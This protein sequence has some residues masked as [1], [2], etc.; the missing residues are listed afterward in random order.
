MSLLGAEYE[1]YERKCA[2]C[3]VPLHMAAAYYRYVE[4][5]IAP[6]GFLKAVLMNDLCAAASR[7]DMMNA[8]ALVEH[9]RFCYNHLPSAAWGCPENYTVWLQGGS[10]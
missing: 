5:R 2:E 7:A 8:R 10:E 1:E 9:V 6:G 4:Q 3:G